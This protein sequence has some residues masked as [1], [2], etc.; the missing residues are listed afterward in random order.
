MNYEFN[1]YLMNFLGNPSSDSYPFGPYPPCVLP[2][3]L[4]HIQK[5]FGKNFPPYLHI[6][7]FLIMNLELSLPIQK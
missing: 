6:G 5:H 4:C 7:S 1:S 3:A 2:F